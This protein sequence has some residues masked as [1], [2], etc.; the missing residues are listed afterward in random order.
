MM[1]EEGG[2]GPGP[3]LGRREA[4]GGDDH[5]QRAAKLE[6]DHNTTTATATLDRGVRGWGPY[7]VAAFFK[8]ELIDSGTPSQFAK[9]N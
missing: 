1:I 8:N 5:D 2:P 9:L 7:T 4:A 3:V 6:G